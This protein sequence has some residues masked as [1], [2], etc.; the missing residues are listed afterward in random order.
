MRG[1]GGGGA[2]LAKRQGGAAGAGGGGGEHGGAGRAAPEGDA[3]Q[4]RA[5]GCAGEAARARRRRRLGRRKARCSGPCALRRGTAPRSRRT[6]RVAC[7]GAG[8]PPVR[9]FGGE[10]GCVRCRVWRGGL[11][12]AFAGPGAAPRGVA[13]LRRVAGLPVTVYPNGRAAGS[14]APR[15]GLLQLCR[16]AQRAAL[17]FPLPVGDRSYRA[18]R[19]RRRYRVV[20]SQVAVRSSSQVA[21]RASAPLASRVCQLMPGALR[22]AV[23]L[24]AR[25]PLTNR[26]KRPSGWDMTGHDVSAVCR[27]FTR[28]HREM[29][30]AI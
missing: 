7:A 17:R 9:D 6:E 25:G 8:P 24:V 12:G 4:R 19:A 1:S 27:R 23:D 11:G 14:V 18:I 21:P 26:M 3:G 15:P 16:P 13:L 20:Q 5:G 10:A 28:S 30:M 2:A 22:S 29:T